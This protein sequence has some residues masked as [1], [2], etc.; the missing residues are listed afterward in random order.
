MILNVL[1]ATD[2]EIPR[3]VKLRDNVITSGRESDI[4]E[5]RVDPKLVQIGL[6]SQNVLKLIVKSPSFVLF[7][8]K[9]TQLVDKPVI[10]MCHLCK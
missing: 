10:C 2:V 7:G 1:K 9:R 3:P 5:M 6:G 8:T 4:R